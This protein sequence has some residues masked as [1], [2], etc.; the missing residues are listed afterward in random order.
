MF[1][2]RNVMLTKLWA[3]E[4]LFKQVGRWLN[5]SRQPLMTF[6]TVTHQRRS[7]KTTR[8]TSGSEAKEV[9]FESKWHSFNRRKAA[10]VPLYFSL[11]VLF[12]VLSFFL[13]SPHGIPDT[14]SFVPSR[15]VRVLAVLSAVGSVKWW[16]G[17]RK[18]EQEESERT[19]L[20]TAR[21]CGSA[22]RVCL[23][24]FSLPQGS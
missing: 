5:D 21:V 1:H 10:Y 11:W 2:R 20:W 16:I 3:T 23:C 13:S 17:E 24:R 12:A 22:G 9:I 6:D 19:K 7:Y 15:C 8:Y 4:E 14:G 18:W